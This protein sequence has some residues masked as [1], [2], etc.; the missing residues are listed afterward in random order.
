M[1]NMKK[2][3]LLLLISGG[4]SAQVVVPKSTT[5]FSNVNAVGSMTVGGNLRVTGSETITGQAKLSNTL[6]I[7]GNTTIN[8]N[9][10]NTLT[11]GNTGTVAVLSDA[12]FPIRYTM[13]ALN[14]SDGSSYYVSDL[15]VNSNSQGTFKMY[16]PFNCTLVGYTGNFSIN[17]TLGT[18]ES[19]TLNIISSGVTSSTTNITNTFNMSTAVASFTASGL[20]VN[21]N[22]GTYVE[23]QMICPTWV[24]NPTS[25]YSGFTLWFVRRQ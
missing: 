8:S 10:T 6:N 13:Y 16:V 23:I 1:Y 3:I 25:V 19:T 22:T 4:L 7:I 9:Q 11:T 15:L 21:M 20:S 12:V 17:G 14:P 5:T 24:T 18:S 2:L